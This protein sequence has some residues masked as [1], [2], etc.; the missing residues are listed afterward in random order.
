MLLEAIRNFDWQNEPD[1]HL[2]T[3]AFQIIPDKRTDFWQDARHGISRDNGHFFF[4][5]YVGDFN[6]SVK[7]QIE[8]SQP[9][10]AQCG[11]M[12]RIDE[13]NW[14]KIALTRNSDQSWSVISS[15]T[16]NGTSDLALVPLNVISDQMS[17]RLE[18]SKGNC[19]FAYSLNGVDFVR[20]R[21]FQMPDIGT[22]TKVGAYICNPTDEDFSAL[23]LE[24]NR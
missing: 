8:S 2:E 12:G 16:R 3:D 6:V 20:I 18:T 10:G 4:T 23:L 14:C 19:C 13:R 7:W 5:R 11:L 22:E 21:L 9:C 1:F 24:I 15:V 17:Y